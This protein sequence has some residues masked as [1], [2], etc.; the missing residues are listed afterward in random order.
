MNDNKQDFFLG[1]QPILNREQNI[2]AYELLFRS[3]G[4]S[5]A[6]NVA[7]DL[8]AT[9]NVILQAFA[10]LGIDT[11]LSSHRGF[12]NVSADL[13]MSEMVELLPRDRV[14]LE[15]LETITIT[16]EV[17]ERCRE[18]KAK[19]FSLA[20]DDFLFDDVYLPLFDIVDVIKIDLLA[21]KPG[22]LE[23]YVNRLRHWPVQ[24]LA[25]KI[26]T[27]EQARRCMELGFELFQGYY[28]AKPAILSGRRADPAHLALLKLLGL[29][30]SDAETTELE[31]IFKRD[32]GLT[33]NLL[34]LVN[35][36]AMG[37]RQKITSL[38]HAIVVLGRH[39]L[40]RWLQLLLFAH[41]SAGNLNDPLLQLAATRGRL[42]EL[43]AARV[44]PGNRQTEEQ[45]FMAGI[46]SLID[47]LLAMP[48]E[49]IV[50]QLN[51]PDAV[52]NAILNRQGVLG[53]MLRLGEVM[54]QDD[55]AAAIAI[56]PRLPGLSL[57]TASRAQIEALA[58]AT[59]LSVAA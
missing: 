22:Q 8:S 25:E 36:V 53:E 56:L 13:L 24:L 27:P 45:A 10:D 26:D 48:K 59:N 39:Q 31:Q 2:V 57:A 44:A 29:V 1:R 16:P 18:L 50:D 47:T 3:S 11:V 38:N 42:M 41:R 20:L 15:L 19:G 7:D 33:Y 17:V 43:L 35:S 32:P 23:V 51:L 37:M 6:A 12:I 30:L 49:E 55:Y 5:N 54:E 21:L 46:M 28:F 4:G 9:A 14:V 52:R 58:W 34:K 40:Q